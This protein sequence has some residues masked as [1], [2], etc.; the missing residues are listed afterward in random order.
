MDCITESMFHYKW[1]NKLGNT[2]SIV[3]PKVLLGLLIVLLVQFEIVFPN[4]IVL[5][6]VLVVQFSL[7]LYC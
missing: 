7:K 2:I 3:L 6:I 4:V 1:I 5:A